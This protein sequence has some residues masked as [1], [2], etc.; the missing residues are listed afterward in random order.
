MVISKHAQTEMN[1][2]DRIMN[3]VKDIYMR[4]RHF[5][6]TQRSQL[7]AL[8][9][10]VYQQP[11]WKR[12]TIATRSYVRGFMDALSEYQHGQ[13]EHRYYING[14]WM[15]H[16]EINKLIKETD[17]SWGIAADAPG[18]FFWK[19]VF[20][21]GPP[22]RPYF[23]DESKH[24]ICSHPECLH[25]KKVVDE[26]DPPVCVRPE[27]PLYHTFTLTPSAGEST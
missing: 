23:L 17:G 8:T 7:D 4:A 22:L 16:D 12:A 19:E 1:R 27:C 3:R 13:Q 14:K 2:Q 5:G 24:Q 26:R 25:P 21:Y 10:E 11:D 20:T 18:G 6:W 15:T 9:K